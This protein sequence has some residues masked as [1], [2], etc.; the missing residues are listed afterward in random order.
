LI[1]ALGTDTGSAP[2]GGGRDRALEVFAA[3]EGM[4]SAKGP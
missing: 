4:G 1:A 3:R 2:I